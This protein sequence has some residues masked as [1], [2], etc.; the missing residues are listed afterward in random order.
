M[1]G[2]GLLGAAVPRGLL[3]LYL[4]W[5]AQ[6]IPDLQIKPPHQ[7]LHQ[8]TVDG[9]R[10][11]VQ[12]CISQG[13]LLSHA[14]LLITDLSRPGSFWLAHGSTAWTS[15]SPG[16]AVSAG[17]GRTVLSGATRGQDSRVCIGS[18][19]RLCCYVKRQ[20]ELIQHWWHRP[21]LEHSA[22][23]S[24]AAGSGDRLVQPLQ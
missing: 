18:R 8:Q 9:T 14:C 21:A 5:T 19:S 17:A 20:R 12:R 1:H 23:L 13:R 10:Q 7:R 22:E 3:H 6:H 11:S 2:P 24:R 16:E 4:R 15:A